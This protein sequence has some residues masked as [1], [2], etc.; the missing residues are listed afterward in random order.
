MN[1][2]ICSLLLN[3]LI[4]TIYFFETA[5]KHVEISYKS[6]AFPDIEIFLHRWKRQHS[7]K[8]IVVMHECTLLLSSSEFPFL[9]TFRK[10]KRL[11]FTTPATPVRTSLKK[12]Y[13]SYSL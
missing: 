1:K 2:V 8:V 11:S 10:V 12:M 13:L 9:C 4:F 5:L 7:R 6:T 3:F